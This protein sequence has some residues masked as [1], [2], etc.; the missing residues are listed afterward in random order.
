MTDSLKGEIRDTAYEILTEYENA[1]NTN[2]FNHPAVSAIK[3]QLPDSL[4]ANYSN[5]PVTADHA[6]FVGR[7]N[8]IPWVCLS[9]DSV[10]EAPQDG[11][12]VVYLFDYQA[13][14]LILSLGHGTKKPR[15]ELGKQGALDLL[16]SRVDEYR[17]HVSVS[18]FTEEEPE[19]EGTTNRSELWGPATV[20]YKRYTPADFPDPDSFVDDLDRLLE[21][22][23][24]IVDEGVLETVDRAYPASYR[25]D[26]ESKE[27]V[28]ET[29]ATETR[30]PQLYQVILTTDRD[31]N[32][33]ANYEQTVERDVPSEAV[34]RYFEAEVGTRTRLW[35]APEFNDLQG[36]DILLFA[37]RAE[38]TIR[39]IGRV[40]ERTTLDPEEAIE[41]AE[42]VGWEH[43]DSSPYTEIVLFDRLWEAAITV[44][45]LW[46]VLDYGGFPIATSFQRIKTELPGSTFDEKYGSVREFPSLATGEL[47]F[48]DTSDQ[49]RLDHPLVDHA[50]ATDP[51]VWTFNTNPSDIL[52]NIRRSAVQM[53]SSKREKWKGIQNGDIVLLR[54]KGE[55]SKI[56]DFDDVD[57][58]GIVGAG[59]VSAHSQKTARW[60]WNEFYSLGYPLLLEFKEVYI[61]DDLAAMDLTVPTYQQSIPTL[62]S[63]IES[64]LAANIPFNE[65]EELVDVHTSQQAR[66]RGELQKHRFNDGPVAFVNAIVDG[67][68][69]LYTLHESAETAGDRTDPDREPRRDRLPGMLP[70]E[71]KPDRADELETQLRNTGQLVLYGPPGTGK[72]YTARR[73][74][75]WWLT[76]GRN[77]VPETR[78]RTVTFHPSFAYEDFMEGLTAEAT[79]EG[80][81]EY[82]Y[83]DGVFKQ[84]CREAREAYQATIGTDES[85]P[86]YVLLI[87]E[88][89]RGNLAKIFGEA[90]TQLEL[91]KR[92]D[93]A[94]STPAYWAHSGEEIA[95]P[96]NVFLIGTMN[97][98]DQSITLVDAA[99][100]RRFS[101]HSFPPDFGIMAEEYDLES[102]PPEFRDLLELSQQVLEGINE[103]IRQANE[104]GRGKQIGHSYLLG[105]DNETDLVNAW[106]FEILPLLEEYYFGDIQGL[107]ENILDIDEPARGSFPLFDMDRLEI[108]DLNSEKLERGLKML[109]K[110]EASET[111]L[112]G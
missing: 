42:A 106:Q 86:A 85:P 87:D 29:A 91:D 89:N 84:L 59:I 100:R 92:L 62:E 27:V 32:I 4:D 54:C 93:G 6:K 65:F 107:V 75:R 98:A 13:N 11:L 64:L 68:D 67:F 81:V 76:G 1:V 12:Y 17:N 103:R 40:S 31:N 110:S 88:L 36:G 57:R 46:D 22:Y 72:T 28:H 5:D 99:I 56:E 49:G 41:F 14:Q 94:E 78:F 53:N 90:I 105:H 96:P 24:Q 112:G 69:S 80:Q 19:L 47:V 37:D 45:E 18:G 111:S 8:H 26:T 43:D 38:P 50:A 55:E 39:L 97:T 9:H 73:F 102:M 83:K 44:D 104:L 35:G 7:L 71:D 25:D 15:D 52:T 74:A 16:T 10:D 48:S 63:E 95:I 21:E 51:T 34:E 79:A 60:W 58:P 2:D 108:A 101:F 70:Q 33:W 77:R 3:N 61:A 20:C 109:P 30:G 82:K 66:T 23:L